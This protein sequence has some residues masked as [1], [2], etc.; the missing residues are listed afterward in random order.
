MKNLRS[1][2]LYATLYL[3]APFL[4]TSCGHMHGNKSEIE[5]Y[6]GQ[7]RN[8]IYLDNWGAPNYVE[9]NEDGN[10]S[11]IYL[12]SSDHTSES[13][14]H[15][16]PNYH[17]TDTNIAPSIQHLWCKTEF[18]I[19]DKNKIIDADWEGNYCTQHAIKLKLNIE[20]KTN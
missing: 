16:S 12:W 19:D 1:R 5:S 20:N 17:S 8:S 6:I 11:L 3:F 14:S 10:T 7:Y 15:F 18:K 9:T 13:T 4:L 2:Y